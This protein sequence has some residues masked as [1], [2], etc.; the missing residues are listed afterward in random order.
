MVHK[1]TF[2]QKYVNTETGEQVF[3]CTNRIEGAWKIAKD[4]FRSI[5]GSNTN[6]FEQ[7][8]CEIVWR[9]HTYRQNVYSAFFELLTSIFTLQ[10][11][12]QF[13]YTKPVFKTWTPPTKDAEK[14]HN[15]TIVQGSDIESDGEVDSG[16]PSSNVTQQ[17]ATP[18]LV[19]KRKRA[20][21]PSS[22][23]TQAGPST[24]HTQAHT[25]TQN[26]QVVSSNVVDLTHDSTDSTDDEHLLKFF[27]PD[28]YKPLKK[29]PKGQCSTGNTGQRKAKGKGKGKGKGKT[30]NQYS[31]KAFVYEWSSDDDFV[32]Q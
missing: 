17:E 20:H 24:Q 3:C 31:K 27:F 7:H 6:Q 2:K 14:N 16:Q 19:T 21:D 28:K 8:L 30:S 32:T 22:Q 26:T 29:R 13:T 18:P 12:A 25:S 9:N 23:T 4:H 11:P 5:N 10:S 1:S 15:I